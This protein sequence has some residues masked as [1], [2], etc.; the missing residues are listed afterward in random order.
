MTCYYNRLH[1]AIC[2]TDAW[3]HLKTICW[4]VSINITIFLGG[5]FLSLSCYKIQNQ[6]WNISVPAESSSINPSCDHGA[7]STSV[8]NFSIS[9]TKWKWNG[10][11]WPCSGLPPSATRWPQREVQPICSVMNCKWSRPDCGS[12]GG[13]KPGRH[14]I[15]LTSGRR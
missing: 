14:I 5:G 11:L 4:I 1:A 9:F 3:F 2:W 15:H 12:V 10:H 8:W 13:V 6:P 7:T